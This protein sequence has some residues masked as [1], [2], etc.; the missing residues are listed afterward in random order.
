MNAH[1][2]W[3]GTTPL[4]VDDDPEREAERERIKGEIARIE[5][6]A[7]QREASEER[8]R[9]AVFM[10]IG[11]ASV[12]WE[13]MEGTGAGKV[14]R[15]RERA[16]RYEC[17]GCGETFAFRALADVDMEGQPCPNRCGNVLSPA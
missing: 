12:C 7:K 1:T 13:H 16:A 6:A 4:P 3:D 2:E 15:S 9:E 14:P 10:A 8:L 5:S 11:A 17:W